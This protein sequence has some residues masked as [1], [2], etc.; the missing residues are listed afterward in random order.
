MTPCP[1]ITMRAPSD[2]PKIIQ[3]PGSAVSTSRTRSLR[4]RAGLPLTETIRWSARPIRRPAAPTSARF[5]PIQRR[6]CGMRRDGACRVAART[7]VAPDRGRAPV[8]GVALQWGSG[9][10]DGGNKHGMRPLRTGVDKAPARPDGQALA[11]RRRA[12]CPGRGAERQDRICASDF[13][14]ARTVPAKAGTSRLLDRV[15]ET[16]CPFSSTSLARN[17]LTS[18]SAGRVTPTRQ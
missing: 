16:G 11:R 1:S 8:R 12:P 4:V 5:T 17:V 7:P 6:G 10:L 13:L 18:R 15:A 3:G 14:L 2:P 9:V